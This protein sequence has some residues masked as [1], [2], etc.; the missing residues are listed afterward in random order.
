MN[1]LQVA[2]L[3]ACKVSGLPGRHNWSRYAP[4]H[5]AWSAYPAYKIKLQTFKHT[6]NVC[7]RVRWPLALL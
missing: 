6:C 1:I 3:V 2:H 5:D 4:V 7:L